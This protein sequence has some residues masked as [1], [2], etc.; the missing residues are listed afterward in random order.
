ME[1]TDFG[2]PPLSDAGAPTEGAMSMDPDMVG[3]GPY[4]D[5]ARPGP[6]LAGMRA[7]KGPMAKTAG[8]MRRPID[9][10]TWWLMGFI[11]AAIITGHI[12]AG[13]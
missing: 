4:G 13:R 11:G 12:A 6:V 10:P 9:D 5:P 8:P 2:F 3:Y 1:L 7:G